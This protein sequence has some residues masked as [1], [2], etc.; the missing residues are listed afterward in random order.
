MQFSCRVIIPIYRSFLFPDEQISLASIR[1]QISAYRICFV[2]PESLDLR[3]IVQSGEVVERFPDEFF[4]GLAGYNRLLKSSV[5]FDRFIENDYILI[6]Q[7][8]CLIFRND[9][10][11]WM[12]QGW[13]YLAAPW[14]KGFARNHYPGLWRVG[15]GGLSLRRVASH[16][17]VLNQVTVKG[18][19]YPRFG[20]S[21]WK[22]SLARLYDGLYKKVASF[23]GLLPGAQKTSVEEELKSYTYNEDVFW[24]IEA[25]KFDVGFR[26]AT[27]IEALPFAFEVDPRWCYKKNKS[28]L[29]FGCHAWTRYDKKFWDE[30]INSQHS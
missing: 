18:A 23:A 4:M 26:V 5:F 15:N 8:D 29:P 25:R 17:R 9:L 14:F 27:A 20:N 13:D 10:D 30:I 2:V 11:H 22:E 24:S 6:A 28:K 12:A 21:Y 7:L 3:E 16:L 1:K 19:I